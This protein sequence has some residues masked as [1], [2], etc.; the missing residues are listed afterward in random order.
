MNDK[1]GVMVGRRRGRA[2]IEQIVAEFAASGV[3]RTEFCRCHGMTLGTLHR[4]LK[5]SEQPDG[6]AP[7]GGLLAVELAGT[8]LT[9]DGDAGCGL[10]VVLS[11]GRRIEVEA[12]FDAPTLERLVTL[13][14]KM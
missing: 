4:Y 3:R 5:L 2:E 11:R 7:Q 12:G 6:G 1:P 8:T 10:A 13:L 9:T 14:E